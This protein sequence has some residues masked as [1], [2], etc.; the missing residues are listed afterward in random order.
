M[1][2]EVIEKEEK[3]IVMSVSPGEVAST[4]SWTCWHLSR[5]A[6][7]EG[8]KFMLTDFRFVDP[9]KDLTYVFSLL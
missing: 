1:L 4:Q 9:L 6:T 2:I 5:K 8:S 3:N 7:L